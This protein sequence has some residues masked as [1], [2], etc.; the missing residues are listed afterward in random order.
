MDRQ[1]SRVYKDGRMSL[2]D[3]LNTIGWDTL[4]V[5]VCSYVI[6]IT[7]YV[8]AV[9]SKSTDDVYCTKVWKYKL[10]SSHFHIWIPESVWRIRSGYCSQLLFHTFR[11]E[12]VRVI[13]VLTRLVLVRVGPWVEHIGGMTWYK[14]HTV[15][16]WIELVFCLLHTEEESFAWLDKLG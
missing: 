10:L 3:C 6:N 16:W 15:D 5:S 9:I 13:R 14:K 11:Q 8:E 7:E 1:S 4:W 12:I 2:C